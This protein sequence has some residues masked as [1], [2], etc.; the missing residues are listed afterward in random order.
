MIPFNYSFDKKTIT[1]IPLFSELNN[2]EL[3]QISS[4]SHIKKFN[5][6]ELIFSD[7][8]KY[9]GF[10]IVLKGKVKVFKLSPAGK[11]SV[12]HIFRP[13][14]EFAE[15]PLFEQLPIYPV[16]AQVLEDT[17]LYFIPNIEFFKFTR[18]N[19]KISFKIIAGFAK[20]LLTLTQKV[21]NLILSDIPNRLAKYI[22]EEYNKSHKLVI[23]KPFITLPI[24]KTNLAGYL[25]TITETLSR[26]FKKLQDEN[27]LEIKGRKI[28][29]I[30]FPAL[31]KLSM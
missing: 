16:N 17:V 18:D 15:V 24:S 20:K 14:E 12:L 30:D 10:F 22:I 27:I 6:N 26:T 29:I 4:F 31:R 2:D 11:E 9:T 21:E 8:D 7:G 13:F 5:K 23:V 3:E 28:Y 25:G 19:P 1:D